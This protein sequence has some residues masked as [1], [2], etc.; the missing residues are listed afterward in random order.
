VSK[1]KVVKK[2]VKLRK[3]DGTEQIFEVTKIAKIMDPEGKM[4]I[5]IH[6]DRL[7]DGSWRL[8]YSTSCVNELANLVGIDILEAA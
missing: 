7:A 1:G 3:A 4:E 8:V 5:G 2:R 6:F